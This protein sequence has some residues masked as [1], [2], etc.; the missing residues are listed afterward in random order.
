[1]DADHPSDTQPD[2]RRAKLAVVLPVDHEH[3]VPPR[4][5]PPAFDT[6]LEALRALEVRV[7]QEL[8]AAVVRDAACELWVGPEEPVCICAR[9]ENCPVLARRLR[10]SGSRR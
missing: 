5:L 10:N 6:S 1:M 2:E 4:D 8:E 7:A 9:R 3:A